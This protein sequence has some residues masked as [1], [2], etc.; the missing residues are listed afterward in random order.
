MT[1]WGEALDAAKD[2]KEFGAV[3]SNLFAALETAMEKEED[4]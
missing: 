4:E 2:G 1:A 3:V